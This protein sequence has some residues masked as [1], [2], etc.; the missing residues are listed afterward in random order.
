M[1]Q[2]RGWIAPSFLLFLLV[3]SFLIGAN[4]ELVWSSITR[5]ASAITAEFVILWPGEAPIIAAIIAGC[6]AWAIAARYTKR[7][8]QIEATLE[9]SKRFHELIQQQRVLNRKYDE[10]RLHCKVA[11][12][13]DEL[14]RQDADAWWWGFFDL[15][16]YEYDFYQKGMV[17]KGRF[18]EWMVWRWHAFHPEEGKEWKTCGIEYREAWTAWTKHPAQPSRLIKLLN[19]IHGIGVPP[20]LAQNDRNRVLA[21]LVRIEVKPHGPRWWKPTDLYKASRD[22]E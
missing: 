1:F 5:F 14:D 13:V 11:K 22:G 16:Q 2:R 19:E 20:N 7:L 9:F 18:E 21:K 3:M 10:A 6:F 4:R 12:E 15:L 8:K 17:R